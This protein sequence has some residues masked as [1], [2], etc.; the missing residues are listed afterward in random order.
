MRFTGLSVG[1]LDL[2]AHQVCRMSVEDVMDYHK[3]NDSEPMV[4]ATAPE[5]HPDTEAYC[6]D[7]E[8]EVV[9]LSEDSGEFE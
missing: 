6:S 8:Q 7:D 9:A 2:Q 1:N 5:C 4:M 3:V